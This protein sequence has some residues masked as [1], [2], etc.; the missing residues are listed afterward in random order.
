[1]PWPRLGSAAGWA[2]AWSGVEVVKL[3]GMVRRDGRS[4]SMAAPSGQAQQADAS[5]VADEI[6][7]LKMCGT[8]T[9]SGDPVAAGVM[10]AIFLAAQRPTSLVVGS[11]SVRRVC[12]R[13]CRQ[14]GARLR[15]DPP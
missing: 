3:S 8:C 5:P 13:R 9:A 7:A 10:A 2:A 15:T 1:M 6:G 11:L 4:A 14:R 12:C